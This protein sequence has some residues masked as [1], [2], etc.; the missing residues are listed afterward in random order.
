MSGQKQ[1]FEKKDE[2]NILKTTRNF[3]KN[4]LEYPCVSMGWVNSYPFA[5]EITEGELDYG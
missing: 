4:L 3:G 2:S 1:C 5:L